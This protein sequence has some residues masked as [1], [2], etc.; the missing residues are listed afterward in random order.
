MPIPP[1]GSGKVAT[2]HKHTQE[3]LRLRSAAALEVVQREGLP[4]LVTRC[5]SGTDAEKEQ[6]AALLSFIATHDQGCACMIGA[7]PDHRTNAAT[8]CAPPACNT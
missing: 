7:V 3:E 8:A 6:A 2:A 5:R 4:N 1:A